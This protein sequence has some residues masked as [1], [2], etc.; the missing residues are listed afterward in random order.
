MIR[1][2]QNASGG[3]IAWSP[4]ITGVYT[5]WLPSKTKKSTSRST[6]PHPRLSAQS[7]NIVEF[8]EA[9]NKIRDAALTHIARGDK[10]WQF[11][12]FPDGTQY[13]TSSKDPNYVITSAGDVID[14]GGTR[15]KPDI[16][17]V[18]KR[19]EKQF[20]TRV[21][22]NAQTD[23]P[24][25]TFKK[26]YDSSS[27]NSSK[28]SSDTKEGVVTSK[29]KNTSRPRRVVRRNTITVSPVKPTQTWNFTNGKLIAPKPQK[30]EAI[31]NFEE[32]T[33]RPVLDNNSN[34]TI[35]DRNYVRG[36]RFSNYNNVNEFLDYVKNNQNSDEARLLAQNGFDVNNNSEEISNMLAS[37]GIRG[38]LG[39]RD[40]RRLGNVLTRLREQ[41]TVGTEAHDQFMQGAVD[42]FNA[43]KQLYTPKD[44]KYA[45]RT[46]R[47]LKYDPTEGI[48]FEG[49]DTN[50]MEGWFKPTNSSFQNYA[51][52]QHFTL[53]YLQS[54]V[55][56]NPYGVSNPF[57]DM[58]G[59][60]KLTFG[61]HRPTT[62]LEYVNGWW[63]PFINKSI[64]TPGFGGYN[65]ATPPFFKF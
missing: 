50:N 36:Q 32:L 21:Q 51:R 5:Q 1:K 18:K 54:F 38:N 64:N 48:S 28:Q 55:G 59:N 37:Q 11:G 39:R 23:Q 61:G 33:S 62:S 16:Q 8:N 12:R 2:Y 26:T 13:V 29:K 41:S 3:S 53:P 10:N 15:V 40:S 44:G 14:T 56:R 49:N 30:N 35:Y 52:N 20:Q 46:F 31:S 22:Y 47:N 60:L 63:M 34:N 24:K 65:V 19:G 57:F 17:P 4:S 27:E 42:Q 7:T 43:T 25:I 6:N 45:G 9:S 58:F